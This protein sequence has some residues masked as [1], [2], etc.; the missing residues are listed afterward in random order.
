MK[1]TDLDYY[2]LLERAGI[3]QAELL[4]RLG[5]SPWTATKWRGNPPFY[6]KAYLSLLIE[7]NKLL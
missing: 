1:Y 4:R 7:K 6:V 2:T 5:L 3:N